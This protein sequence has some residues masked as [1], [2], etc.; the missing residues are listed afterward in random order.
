MISVLIGFVLGGLFV[1]LL[2]Y[3]RE[4]QQIVQMNAREGAWCVVALNHYAMTLRLTCKS[5]LG[6]PSKE[7]EQTLNAAKECTSIMHAIRA[8]LPPPD[9]EKP[10]F[11]I[12]DGGEQDELPLK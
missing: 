10:K 9:L 7:D 5:E 4:K 2:L 8:K 11:S 6:K 12:L 1:C 3:W